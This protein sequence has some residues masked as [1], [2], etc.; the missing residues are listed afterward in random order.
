MFLNN[1]LKV[2][3]LAFIMYGSATGLGKV[4]WG[5]EWLGFVVTGT[6]LFLFVFISSKITESR[7]SRDLKQIKQIIDVINISQLTKDYPLYSVGIAGALGF[8][9]S[10]RSSPLFAI[11]IDVAEDILKASLSELKAELSNCKSA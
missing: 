8:I 6:V 5:E 1:I 3:A 7:K 4:L 10:N 11:A 9:M 2:F